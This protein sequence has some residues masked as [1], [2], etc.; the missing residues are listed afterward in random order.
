MDLMVSVVLLSCAVLSSH[1]TFLGGPSVA[2]VK[3]DGVQR[4]MVFAMNEYNRRSNDMFVNNWYKVNNVT[5][6]IVAGVLYKID[7]VVAR[8]KCKKPTVNFPS[9][10][11]HTDPSFAKNMNCKFEVL[12]VPWQRRNELKKI[13]CNGRTIF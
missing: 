13:E 8:T 5:K 12:A 4:A 9:C 2:S 10:A 6:Q 11:F 7:A 1:S 3:E